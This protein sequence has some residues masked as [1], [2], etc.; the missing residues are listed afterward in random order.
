MPLKAK[1]SKKRVIQKPSKQEKKKRQGKTK[2]RVGVECV[3]GFGVPVTVGV[4]E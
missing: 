4:S 1:T 3:A 2:D